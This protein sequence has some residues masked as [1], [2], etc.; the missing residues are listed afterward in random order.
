MK[1]LYNLQGAY[2]LLLSYVD[3][4]LVPKWIYHVLR[5]IEMSRLSKEESN[6]VEQRSNYYCQLSKIKQNNCERPF[7]QYTQGRGESPIRE[8]S[9]SKYQFPYRSNHRFSFYFFDLYHILKYFPKDKAFCF[10]F[11]DVWTV[12]PKPTLLK[13]R[14]IT[15]GNENAVLLKLNHHRHYRFVHD[16]TPFR[17]KLD[18]IVCR[19]TWANASPQ[20]RLFFQKF[21]NHPFFDIGKTKS[22]PNEDFPESIK[23]Y[24]SIQQQLRYKFIVCIEGNDVATSLKWVMSSNSIA[25][26]PPLK[27]ETWFMEGLLVPDYHFICVK[28]DYSD[29]VE[30][31]LYYISHEDEAESIIRHA[32]EWVARFRNKRLERAV[33]IEV[34][35]KYFQC[36]QRK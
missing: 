18:M 4:L 32:H 7:I 2:Y 3:Y 25:V 15:S 31:V 9:I 5:R 6:E 20:R 23:P 26:S 29:L 14:P 11:G 30:K 16:K 36:L 8:T 35:D 34:A 19:T 13:S 12:P 22:E 17:D 24:L 28:S 10:Q 1:F 33:G 27:F 21:L